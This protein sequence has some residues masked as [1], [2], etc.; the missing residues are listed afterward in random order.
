VIV[1]RLSNENSP[2]LL[3][4][5]ENPVDWY[6]WGEA[7]FERARK[8]DK[9]IFLS[10]GYAACHWCHVMAHESFEDADTATVMNESFVNIKVDREERPDLD[11]IYMNAVVAMTGQGGW[12]MSVF[13]TPD[14][15]P[16]FGGTYF[17][18]VSR[19]NLPSFREVLEYIR[20]AWRNNREPLL[21]SGKEIGEHLRQIYS[22]GEAGQNL[23]AASLD[24]AAFALAQAYD[25]KNGGWG[26]APKFPQPM[27]I[28]YL[29]KRASHGDKF[30]LEIATH[31]LSVMA[32]GGMY[33]VVG[34]G[35]ARY[36]TDGD[37]LIPHF[38]K[39]LYD[40]AQLARVYLHAY[41]LTEKDEFLRICK[42]TSDFITRE[43]T[44]PM[45]GFYSSLD[46]DSEGQEGR[47]YLWTV[48]QI[49]D[50][51]PHPED[52]DL[53]IAAYGVTASGNF[54]GS[55]VLQRTLSDREIADHYDLPLKEIWF[56]LDGINRQLLQVRE[57]RGKPGL[58]DKVLLAW[59]ALGLCLF[60]ECSVYLCVG[61]VE[62]AIRNANFL[63][64]NLWSQTGLMRSWRN[65]AAQHPAFLEDYA[66]L[67][68]ALLSLYQ[69][70][71]QPYWFQ[72][73]YRLAEMM[74]DL[75]YNPSEGFFDTHQGHTHLF[76]RPRDLQDNATPSGTSQAT[77][78][79][80]KLAG[81]TGRD[82]WREIAETSLIP[83]Q[84]VASRYPLAFGN[85]LCTLD[86]ALAAPQEVAIIGN[87]DD[88]RTRALVEAVWS[89]YRPNIIYAQSDYPAP[90]GSPDL[91]VNRP[92]KNGQ[93]TAYV[94][95]N[96]VCKEPV[97]DPQELLAQL[98]G[99][100]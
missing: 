82:D 67:G 52:A 71:P 47:Y 20:D 17:P 2:Y 84:D 56:K 62:V 77:L 24:K 53:A 27:V 8:E 97:T 42:A 92:L 29:L 49:R 14:G 63:I 6:P 87:P 21:R 76:A 69:V 13:L 60:S 50:A 33:D 39:M 73:A 96:L 81:Y 94:C 5:A 54:S 4:H 100:S 9:P 3:Q 65:G 12:P 30:A 38:E 58:D 32:R 22:A 74:L 64:R 18:P 25:W 41:L 10:I 91:L 51:L 79:L 85:W 66:G 90:R 28:E 11:S 86:F 61:W 57:L 55:N 19:H 37:W 88:T 80:L 46:A 70:D 26:H 98:A 15:E 95:K 7:A 43:L 44:H 1:N 99:P 31:A 59:N 36:S 48:D 34:G 45:G 68:L 35:F 16:F 83:L 75:F 93:P 72:T 40:S 23:N 78:L 89:E